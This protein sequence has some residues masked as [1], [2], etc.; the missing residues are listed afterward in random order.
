MIKCMGMWATLLTRNELQEELQAA[1]IDHNKAMRNMVVLWS[2]IIK[3][4]KDMGL[5]I[6][7]NAY[8]AFPKKNIKISNIFNP[9]KRTY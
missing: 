4:S 2:L 5:H 8:E 7:S 6:Y 1:G 3:Y 9:I